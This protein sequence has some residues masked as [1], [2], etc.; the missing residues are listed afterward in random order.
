MLPLHFKNGLQAIR[1]NLKLNWLFT[2][3]DTRVQISKSEE[4]KKVKV[5]SMGRTKSGVK[6]WCQLCKKRW[7][8][9]Y[10]AEKQILPHLFH[11]KLTSIF[12]CVCSFAVHPKLGLLYNFLR[13]KKI[14]G[15][16]NQI[17]RILRGVFLKKR[18]E[19]QLVFQVTGL[20]DNWSF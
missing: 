18:T 1:E 20:F 6:R 13:H 16:D 4:P 11:Q 12:L 8:R 9:S 10:T 14:S 15:N 7:A 3:P 19:T 5:Y 17:K 2:Q